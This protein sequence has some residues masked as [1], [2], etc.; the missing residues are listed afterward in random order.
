MISKSDWPGGA[1]ALPLSGVELDGGVN[2]TVF[3]VGL[4]AD[5]SLDALVALDTP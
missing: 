5:G 1:V 2:Y 4:A 3:A